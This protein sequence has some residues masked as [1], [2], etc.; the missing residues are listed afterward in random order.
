M[1]PSADDRPARLA[2]AR[3]KQRWVALAFG[4]VALVVLGIS[5]LTAKPWLVVAGVGWG[6]ASGVILT[7][8]VRA[9][10]HIRRPK[11]AKV[12]VSTIVL[13]L[14]VGIGLMQN[15]GPSWLRFG[16][17][18]GGVIAMVMATYEAQ[19]LTLH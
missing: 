4:A 1:G 6:V 17:I 12:V 13:A 9:S 18:A 8:A 19:T 16:T 10:L 14:L 5:P 2:N 15:S 3:R 7:F 11:V